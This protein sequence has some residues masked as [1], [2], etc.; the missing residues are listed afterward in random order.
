MVRQSNFHDG[1]W[2]NIKYPFLTRP[3]IEHF[4]QFDVDY[5]M[6]KLYKCPPMFKTPKYSNILYSNKSNWF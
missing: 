6:D 2:R 4:A 1:K 5:R 3:R